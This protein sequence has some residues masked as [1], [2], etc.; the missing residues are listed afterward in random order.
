LA[1]SILS[2]GLLL[3]TAKLGEGLARR[4]HQSSI[5]AY[6]LAG[7]MLGPILRVVQPGTEPR[8][9]LTVGIVFLFFLIGFDELDISGFRA[10]LRWRLFLAGTLAL[11]VPLA[12]ALGVTYYGLHLP[13]AVAVAVSGVL[14]LTS[15]GVVARVLGE[16]GHLREP[17]GIQIFT[18]VVILELLGLLIIAVALGQAMSS[19]GFTV[20]SV[21]LP[22]ARIAGFVVVS[23]L[24]GSRLLPFL[25]VKLRRVFN[26]P[27]MT[28]GL[29]VGVLFLMV[30]AGGRIGL[31]ESLGALL[32][33]S[34]L[35]GIPHRLR[36]E[37]MPGMRSTAH[38]LFIPLFFASAGLYL[39]LSFLSLPITATLSLVMVTI[40]GKMAGALL[41]SRIARVGQTLPMTSGLMAKGVAEIALLLVMFYSG[42]I[43]RD[44]LS[45]LVAIM[46]LFMVAIPPVMTSAMARHHQVGER[47]PSR[48]VPSSF[49]RYALE[50]LKV[51]QIVDKNRRFPSASLS[52]KDFAEQWMVSEQHEYLVTDG[53]R[54][55]AGMFSL[56][57]LR[58][59][60][61]AQWQAVDLGSLVQKSPLPAYLDQEIEDVVDRMAEETV[62]VIPVVDP[63]SGRLLGEIR[64]KD[65]YMTLSG[66]A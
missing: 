5:L 43:G 10:T 1:Q 19:N 56:G 51:G 38:G 53:N 49:A 62:S 25:L 17:L 33:G 66:G 60:P 12:G 23:W 64:H 45:L 58:K 63:E 40:F 11:V 44:M 36:H 18:A 41:A 61:K 39:D 57:S 47:V 13:S 2:I 29:L 28:F 3:L 6:L 65:I 37:V 35:A 42:L 27:E 30:A 7:V 54:E 26:V 46:V 15:L 8:L 21:A 9:F 4:A 52:L 55:L 31:H 34:A 14:A 48:F 20:W 22:L 32:F 24:I 50:G 59:V 16:R